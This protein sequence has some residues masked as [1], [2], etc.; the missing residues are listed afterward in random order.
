MSDF[1][2]HP[3]TTFGLTGIQETRLIFGFEPPSAAVAPNVFT[4]GEI[5]RGP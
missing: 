5:A 2:D 1:V 3:V 4:K